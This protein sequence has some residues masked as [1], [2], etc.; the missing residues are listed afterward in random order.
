MMREVEAVARAEGVALSKD[1]VDMCLAQ[2]AAVGD[3]HTSMRQDL[4]AGRPREHDALV[5]VIV[6]RGA[7]RGVPTP[8]NETILALLAAIS[9]TPSPR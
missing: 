9:P 8:V 1:V 6:R 7:A 2:A 5:G 4:E 3:T